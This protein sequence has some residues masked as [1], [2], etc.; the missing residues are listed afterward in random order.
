MAFFKR[1]PGVSSDNILLGK[2]L[3]SMLV[4]STIVTCIIF[5]PSP[6]SLQF[7]VKDV[8]PYPFR[9]QR[10]HYSDFEIKKHHRIV[11][12]FVNLIDND[13]IVSAEQFFAPHL[14]KKKATMI[15]PQLINQDGSIEADYVLI[16]KFNP[17]KTGSTNVK[18]SWFGLRE[19]PQKYYDIVEKNTNKWELLKKDDGIYLF[20]RKY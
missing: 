1:L 16:D 18:G 15:F 7:W 13:A 2:A 12:D 20:K 6:I 17:L 14:F 10:H 8:R 5:G 3:Q 9:T 4:T 11:P 19:N